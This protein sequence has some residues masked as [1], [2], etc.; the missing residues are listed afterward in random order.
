MHFLIIGGGSAGCVLAAR[1][2]E[3]ESN[4]VTLV[5]AGR[6]LTEASMA[7]HVRTRYPGRAYIDDNNI[8]PDLKAYLGAAGGASRAP[9]R[10][11]QG[12]LLGG[13]SSVNAMVANR[14]APDDYDEWGRLGAA[15]WSWDA[16][17]PYFRK[18]E[19]DVDLKTSINAWNGAA[20]DIANAY[21]DEF[22]RVCLAGKCRSGVPT[23]SIKNLL[24]LDLEIELRDVRDIPDPVVVLARDSD[25]DLGLRA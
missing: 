17:L 10:Y 7:P 3:V 2:S 8:W 14:G 24:A 5:E 21:R 22:L 15:G 12:R 13:G 20:D 4:R 9:R 18:L 25:V 23:P 16:A 11:E 6:D 19:R 1:L